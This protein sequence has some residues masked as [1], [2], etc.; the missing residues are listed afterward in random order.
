[1]ERIAIIDGV[2]TPFIKAFTDF[3]DVPAKSLGSAAVSELL[4][5]LP[6]GADLIDEVVLGTVTT[7]SDAPNIAR[8]VSLLA[9]IPESKR[10]V[11]VSRNCASGMEA[12]TTA[13]EKITAGTND[14]VLASGVESMSNVPLLYRKEIQNF[15]LSMPRLSTPQKIAGF[16]KLKAAFFKPVIGLQK[17]LEDPVCGLNMGQTAE[18]LA[19]DFAISRKDQDEFALQSHLNAAKGRKSTAEEITAVYP[20]P[21]FKKAVTEDNGIREQQTIEALTKLKPYFE[22]GTGTVTAGNSSQL[23]DGAAALLMMKE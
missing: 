22:K 2:R 6:V 16:W 1:M 21:K 3:N 8:V 4:H 10:A 18:V 11:T 12:V 23:T 17:A 15:L 19:K 7:T 5:R 14:V 9:G 13:W 20:S